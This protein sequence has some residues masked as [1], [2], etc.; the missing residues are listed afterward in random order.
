MN[1]ASRGGG[2][3]SHQVQT[4]LVSPPGHHG[5]SELAPSPSGHSFP[6]TKKSSCYLCT[7]TVLSVIQG[8]LRAAQTLSPQPSG[9]WHPLPTLKGA[10]GCIGDPRLSGRPWADRD[11][12]GR[13]LLSHQQTTGK[14]EP[15]GQ[16]PGSTMTGS[17]SVFLKAL[18][19][20]WGGHNFCCCA[21]QTSVR[22]KEYEELNSFDLA[23]F[24]FIC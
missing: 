7:T 24:F 3:D 18:D 1:E 20:K 14:A 10:W 8:C 17:H 6:F 23:S 9:P 15:L 5:G 11:R 19:P 22:E 2:G 13:P 12:G 21:N 16:E 4:T